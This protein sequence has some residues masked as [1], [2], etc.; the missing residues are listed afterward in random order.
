MGNRH[1]QYE[2][3]VPRLS[4]ESCNFSFI[5]PQ[6]LLSL[7]GRAEIELMYRLLKGVDLRMFGY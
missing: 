3:K 4:F 1:D 5:V 6:L 2:R 7:F